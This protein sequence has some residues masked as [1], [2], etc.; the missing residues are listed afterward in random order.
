M[1]LL[2]PHLFKASSREL[3]TLLPSP[4]KSRHEGMG[5]EYFPP[6]GEC[7]PAPLNGMTGLPL[8]SRG[9]DL[10]AAFTTVLT[11]IFLTIIINFLNEIDHL[12]GFPGVCQVLPPGQLSSWPC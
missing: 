4:G 1:P 7:L 6:S 12:S 3:T 8:I 10:P 5:G 11:D 9:T 2:R